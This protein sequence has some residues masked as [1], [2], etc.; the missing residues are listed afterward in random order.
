MPRESHEDQLSRE[1]MRLGVTSRLKGAPPFHFWEIGTT[2]RETHLGLDSAMVAFHR[3]EMRGEKFSE[4][5]QAAY[6]QL[7]AMYFNPAVNPYTHKM[8][9]EDEQTSAVRRLYVQY[10]Y[11]GPDFKLFDP[12]RTTRQIVDHFYPIRWPEFNDASDWEL[13]REV[14]PA[15]QVARAELRVYEE[16]RW[17]YD[18]RSQRAAEVLSHR[19]HNVYPEQQL[20]ERMK[21]TEQQRAIFEE[22]AAKLEKGTNP[23]R[24]VQEAWAKLTRNPRKPR[25]AD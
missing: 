24:W 9:N 6:D 8:L 16:Q 17:L 5:E 23:R 1:L 15:M 12:A 10:G 3:K 21:T 25:K 7:K 19:I 14:I 2:G 20:P 11:D 4:E 18:E 22:Y 13:M